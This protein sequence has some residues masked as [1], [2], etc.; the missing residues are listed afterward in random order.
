MDG[1]DG[2]LRVD[3]AEY[4]FDA[5]R[6]DYLDFLR[7]LLSLAR[8]PQIPGLFALRYSPGSGALLASTRFATTVHVEIAAPRGYTANARFFD[9]VQASALEHGGVPHLGQRNDLSAAQLRASFGQALLEWRRA[10]TR[11]SPRRGRP[12]FDNAFARQRSLEP[13]EQGNLLLMS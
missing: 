6:S 10:L 9:L 4:G 7:E 5:N 8:S 2:A 1:G 11:V 3:S 13:L 12:T